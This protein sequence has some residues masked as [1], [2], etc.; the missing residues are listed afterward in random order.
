[1]HLGTIP[2]IAVQHRGVRAVEREAAPV[3]DDQ[4][5]HDSVVAA[6]LDR[7]GR[8]AGHVDRQRWH[9]FRVSRRVAGG[10]VGV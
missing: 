6:D 2:A 4:W 8:D 1:M 10:V 7:G 9:E 3:Q 5:D